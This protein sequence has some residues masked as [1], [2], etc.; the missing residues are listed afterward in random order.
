MQDSGGGIS[1]QSQQLVVTGRVVTS[2]QD[3]F[4]KLIFPWV[5]DALGVTDWTIKLL[6]PEEKAEETQLRFMQQKVTAA[7]QLRQ[8]GFT[9]KITPGRKAID[10]ISF[11]VTGE[12]TDIR[13]EQAAAQGGQADAGGAP[14]GGG[15]VADVAA[16]GAGSE[17]NKG[18]QKG[19][20]HSHGDFPPHSKKENHNKS[21]NRKVKQETGGEKEESDE[22]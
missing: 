19:D 16:K 12:A 17:P 21:G 8:M 10:D 14:T 6:P 22:D 1:T 13:E 3:R 11:D 7:S 20:L 4:N 2:D 18:S 9:V 5:F 15:D